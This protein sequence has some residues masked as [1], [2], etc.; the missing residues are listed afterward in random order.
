VRRTAQ[1][2]S[3][4]R[5]GLVGMGQ[6][7]HRKYAR[8]TGSI[9]D[10]GWAVGEL[11]VATLRSWEYGSISKTVRSSWLISGARVHCAT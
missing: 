8:V 11:S 9:I 10:L 3:E 4:A 1:V 6:R 5:L 2:D 7:W